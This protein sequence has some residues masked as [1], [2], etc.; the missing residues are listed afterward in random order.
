MSEIKSAK[1]IA[2]AH[3]EYINSDMSKFASVNI[4]IMESV[5]NNKPTE[6]M[7]LAFHDAN[8]ICNTLANCFG[9]DIER[10]QLMAEKFETWDS[11]MD[12][13]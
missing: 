3:V 12:Y 1:E 2:A 7:R 11:Q 5:Q 10:I 13:R 4:S 6:A 9:R 8:S